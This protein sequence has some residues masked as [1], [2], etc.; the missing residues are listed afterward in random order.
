MEEGLKIE[1]GRGRRVESGGGRREEVGRRESPI[2]VRTVKTQQAD[3][4]GYLKKFLKSENPRKE[5]GNSNL[6]LSLDDGQKVME[7]TNALDFK[8]QV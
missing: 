1:D 5:D 3:R 6:A 2:G 4:F 8:K 7:F